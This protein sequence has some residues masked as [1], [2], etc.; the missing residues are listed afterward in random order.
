M[1]IIAGTSLEAKNKAHTAEPN[2]TMVVVEVGE[3]CC[4]ENAIQPAKPP[5]Y[6][7]YYVLVL[8]Y[9][10]GCSGRWNGQGHERARNISLSGLL[11]LLLADPVFLTAFLSGHLTRC[12]LESS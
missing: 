7:L 3:K 10:L 1:T 4:E 11:R 9:G 2:T 12:A 8:P 6:V 5:T